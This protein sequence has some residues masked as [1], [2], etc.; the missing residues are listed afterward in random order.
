MCWE[1]R[2]SECSFLEESAVG[3]VV[4]RVGVPMRA[5][6][7]AF[8]AS[9]W[10]A[11]SLSGQEPP[12]TAL[13]SITGTVVDARTHK[14]VAGALISLPAQG[15]SVVAGR[16]GAF[17]LGSLR[18]GTYQLVVSCRGYRTSQGDLAVVRTGSLRLD[19]VPEA[20]ADTLLLGRVVGRVTD[21]KTG[22][23][24][25]LVSIAI[26]PEGSGQIS[27]AEGRFLFPLVPPGPHLL[28]VEALGYQPREDSV[29]VAEGVTLDVGIPLSPAPLA[30]AGITVTMRSRFLES[31]G[32]FRRKEANYNGRQWMAT[33]LAAIDPMF[34]ED[35]IST[36][37]AVRQRRS[38]TGRK[39]YEGRLGCRMQVYID[40]VRMDDFD[41]DKL[42]P[43]FVE[44]LE[45]YHGNLAEMPPGYGNC[46]VIFVWLKHH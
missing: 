7:V 42:E 14:P 32:F 5:L 17:S 24:L 33:E 26:L 2:S 44:A 11:A 45:V 39:V 3:Q 28:R 34:L 15:L 30:L 16:D 18:R 37:P 38:L 29:N 36:V 46:G 6:L 21:L 20:E 19:L 41:L 23:P 13:I 1:L 43:R 35:V 22:Q 25:P 8:I 9:M 40:D 4:P 31:A 10:L 27:D 12:D